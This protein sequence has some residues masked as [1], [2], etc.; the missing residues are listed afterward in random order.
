MFH[1]SNL[2]YWVKT[3]KRFHIH[4]REVTPHVMMW[5]MLFMR[6]QK[7]VSL[8]QFDMFI[9]ILLGWLFL[10]HN[11]Q[12]KTWYNFN[13]IGF[14]H[15]RQ[16]FELALHA[17]YFSNHWVCIEL[18]Q[19]CNWSR[20]SLASWTFCASSLL[21]TII[22]HPKVLDG[23]KTAMINISMIG[24]RYVLYKSMGRD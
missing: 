20:F 9:G 6:I 4:L 15:V 12:G 13:K 2:S 7:G 14:Y 10:V 23:S 1:V 8:V 22:G 16:V 21:V 11:P 24:M 17:L 18:T 5:E 19:W 3:I